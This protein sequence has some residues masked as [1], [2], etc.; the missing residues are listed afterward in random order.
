MNQSKYTVA[1][2]AAVFWPSRKTG[3]GNDSASM[4]K[5]RPGSPSEF[6]KRCFPSTIAQHPASGIPPARSVLSGGEIALGELN[7][8]TMGTLPR[9]EVDHFY[10]SNFCRF[11]IPSCFRC[12]FLCRGVY[13]RYV[14][15][16]LVMVG[17]H[18]VIPGMTVKP[19]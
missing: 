18:K 16:F 12:F 9:G 5:V 7:D 6:I 15:S 10:A 14:I 19:K 11:S 13:L 17:K 2:R 4:A 1:Q 8:S 3:G